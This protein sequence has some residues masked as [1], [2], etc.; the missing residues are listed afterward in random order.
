MTTDQ[1]LTTKLAIAAVA[2]ILGALLYLASR[3]EE[4]RKA[5]MKQNQRRSAWM[6][7]HRFR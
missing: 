5:K 3:A 4:S 7:K 2:L 6:K 1:Y